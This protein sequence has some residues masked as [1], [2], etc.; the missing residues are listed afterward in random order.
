MA[1]ILPKPN[2]PT[3][4]LPGT[5]TVGHST[6]TMNMAG[7]VGGT[8]SE[9][10]RL[11]AL[12]KLAFLRDRERDAGRNNQDNGPVPT[13]RPSSSQRDTSGTVASAVAVQ[14]L[15]PILSV[16]RGTSPIP[17]PIDLSVLPTVPCGTCGGCLWW[18]VSVLSGGPGPWRCERCERPDPAVW[19]DG[20]AISA[21]RTPL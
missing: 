15:A 17:P 12:R 16:H 21:V 11:T 14:A 1:E 18:R 20:H 10:L 3:V 4:P 6:T 7:T 19:Q 5:G 8:D 9:T 13:V 2:C